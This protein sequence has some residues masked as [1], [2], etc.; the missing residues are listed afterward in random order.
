MAANQPIFRSVNTLF[1]KCLIKTMWLW[2]EDAK[3]K[4]EVLKNIKKPFWALI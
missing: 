1:A 2:C 3:K 4:Q